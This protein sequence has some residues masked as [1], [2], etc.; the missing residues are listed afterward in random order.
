MT[1]NWMSPPV[2]VLFVCLGNICEFAENK[3]LGSLAEI[4]RIASG[5]STM[6]EGVFRH[7]TRSHPAV[8]TVDSCG[9]GAYYHTDDPPDPRTMSVLEEN[10]ITDY[11]HRARTIETSDF[12]NF[13]YILVMD[14]YNL[15][16]VQ[17][18]QRRASGIGSGGA[19]RT[20][21]VMLFGDF[22]GTKG[23]EVIDPYLGERDG[24]TIA[25]EQMVRFSRS[26][27]QQVL[28]QNGDVETS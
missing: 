15:T 28:G 7:L 8:G 6:A 14:R 2:S 26:F 10:G 11:T 16:D 18:L 9:T 23:E 21:K 5:R 1:P 22:G 24:F 20:G 25:Y 3:F 4:M 12:S 17:K 19:E 27:I 13:D